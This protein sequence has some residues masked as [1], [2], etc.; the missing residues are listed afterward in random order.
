MAWRW[1][2]VGGLSGSFECANDD[3]F[4][5]QWKTLPDDGVLGFKFFFDTFSGNTRHA[6][7][8]GGT[9]WYWLQP[10]DNGIVLGNSDDAATEISTRYPGA[11]LKRGQWTTPDDLERV[12]CEQAKAQYWGDEPITIE[13]AGCCGN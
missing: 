9:D 5:A 2:Y 7:N 11:V 8:A 3:E 10:T 13:L 4:L 6:R 1:W 12:E